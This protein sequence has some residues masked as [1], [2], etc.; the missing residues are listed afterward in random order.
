MRL[1]SVAIRSVA[2]TM[3]G[4]PAEFGNTSTMRR[5][6]PRAVRIAST[7][8]RTDAL[9]RHLHMAGVDEVRGGRVSLDRHRLAQRIVVADERHQPVVPQR[10]GAKFGGLARRAAQRR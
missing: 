4:I 8:L 1:G 10:F 7:T 6:N 2:A 5:R 3:K 9:G